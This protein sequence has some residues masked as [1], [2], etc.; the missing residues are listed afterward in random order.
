MG[1]PHPFYFFSLHLLPVACA[2]CLLLVTCCLFLL[3]LF[4]FTC[5]LL[6]VPVACSLWLVAWSLGLMPSGYPAQALFFF[7]KSSLLDFFKKLF[8]APEICIRQRAV[9]I[10]EPRQQ[11]VMINS[12][13]HLIFHKCRR[14]PAVDTRPS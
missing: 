11:V 13:A 10:S 2:C 8:T 3:F 14:P 7:C 5:C 1:G 9:V 4:F 6:L 12:F